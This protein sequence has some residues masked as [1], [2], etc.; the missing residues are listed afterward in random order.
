MSPSEILEALL[1][2]EHD[3]NYTADIAGYDPVVLAKLEECVT[4]RDAI[5]AR[6][7]AWMYRPL[8]GELWAEL[9]EAC[10][11]E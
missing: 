1:E 3:V 9:E 4:R 10:R 6:L 2:A 11:G 5:K 8:S 7:E